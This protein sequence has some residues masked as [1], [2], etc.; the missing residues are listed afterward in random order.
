MNFFT[1]ITFIA[2]ALTLIIHLIREL[3]QP[4]IFNDTGVS[5][6]GMLVMAGVAHLIWGKR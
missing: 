1:T 5:A 6:I 2:G 4:G 3:D